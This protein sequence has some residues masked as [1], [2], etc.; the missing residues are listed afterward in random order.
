MG[1][2]ELKISLKARSFLEK[3][4]IKSL[5]DAYTCDLQRLRYLKRGNHFISD[6]IDELWEY[7]HTINIG[8]QSEERYYQELRFLYQESTKGLN[9]N[10][11]IFLPRNVRTYL[12]TYLTINDFLKALERDNNLLKRF[13]YFNVSLENAAMLEKLFMCFGNSGILLSLTIT[14]YAKSLAE[15]GMFT[16]VRD[17]FKDKGVVNAFIRQDVWFL[18]DLVRL[19][20]EGI[21]G[22]AGFGDVKKRIAFRDLREAGIDLTN[23][24]VEEDLSLHFNYPKIVD[25]GLSKGLQ[26]RLEMLEIKNLEELTN[27]RYL[28]FLNIEEIRELRNRLKT[29]TITNMGGILTMSIEEIDSRYYQKKSQILRAREDIKR[30]EM[31]N[32]GYEMIL[33]LEKRVNHEGRY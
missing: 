26:T 4:G 9:I 32:Y 23:L 16:P 7:M 25:L 10:E 17:L 14:K 1:M 5:D 27:L 6:Y 11:Y 19:Q 12:S 30:L 3:I 28:D 31:E 22:L 20:E 8:F 21:N 29:L 15:K 2:K 24:K 13:L 33:K 18:N